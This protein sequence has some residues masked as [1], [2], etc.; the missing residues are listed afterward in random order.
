MVTN[1][2]KFLTYILL[3]MAQAIVA[4]SGSH[5]DILDPFDPFDK[6]IEK[7]QE[8]QPDETKTVEQLLLEATIL[9]NDERP[10]DA[11]T[12][13]LVALNKDPKEYKTHMMLA[14]YYMQYVGH[15]RLAM[16]YTKQAISLFEEKNGKAPYT[17]Y[18][19]QTEHAHLLYLLSQ[20]R[21]NLDNYKGALDALNEYEAQNYFSSWYPGAKAWVLMK[22]GRIDEAIKISRLGVMAGSEPGRTLNM[23]GILLSMNN[24][25]EESLQVFKEAI[26]FELSLGTLGQP[27]TPLNN[28]GEVYKESFQEDKAE[29]SF[30]RATHLSD[31]C[32]HVLPSLNLSILY[33][34]ELNLRGAKQSMDDFERCIAQFPLR[35]GE[36]HTALVHLARGR[37]DLHNGN[38]DTAIKHLE[39]ANEDRQWFGQIGTSQEDLKAA[40]MIS[41]AQALR[42]KIRHIQSES[43]ESTLDWFSASKD[44]TAYKLRSWWLLRRARQV[45]TE[46]L[47][48]LEDLY[49]RNTD[50]L[51]EYPTFGEVLSALPRRPLENRLSYETQ[52]DN[53]PGA[54]IYYKLYL[55]ENYLNGWWK[56]AGSDLLDQVIAGARPK[57]DDLLKTHA[58]TLKAQRYKYDTPEYVDLTNQ[59]FNLN[60]AQLRNYG[61]PLPVNYINLP[62]E[63]ESLFDGGPLLLDNS[64]RNVFSIRYEKDKDD[65]ILSFL[66]SSLALGNTKVKGKDLGSVARQF[67][68]AIFKQAPPS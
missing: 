3:F 62:S 57:Y 56:Q 52:H 14:G 17:D 19:I 42:A 46:D 11:R 44:V 31:G 67:I 15:F 58:L 43:S 22:L 13:L 8:D 2:L 27:A 28:S 16:K 66:S 30:L 45:L 26:T 55:A 33:I 59:I 37:I 32:E 65:H 6:G 64:R 9:Q 10:L 23:L 47:S 68:D 38:I 49:V 48:D 34:E 63:V 5:A 4:V 41:L 29:S 36:Q 1:R 20:A 53:R 50:S 60:R 24:E 21:L 51:V 35:N 61:L 39:A 40:A 54:V 25:R 7:T 18:Q 12:K